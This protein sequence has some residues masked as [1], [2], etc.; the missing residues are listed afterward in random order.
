VVAAATPAYR[1]PPAVFDLAVR[2]RR[3]T[4]AEV[5]VAHPWPVP[6]A[7]FGAAPSAGVA[8]LMDE[9]GVAFRGGFAFT[10]VHADR[11]V[12]GGGAVVEFDVALLVPPHRPPAVVAASPLAGPDG[13]MRVEFPSLRHLEHRNVFGVGDVIA[14]TLRVGMAGTLGVFEGAFA[15]DRIAAELSGAVPPEAPRMQAICFLDTGTTGSLLHC[16][17]SAPAAGTGPAAC[18]LMPELPFFR[19]AKRLF[20]DDWFTSMVTGEVA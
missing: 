20:A 17:F 11:L 16:D 14:P 1:C 15:A 10:Q 18:T 4:G 9:A 8:R 7:P 12:E 3:H 13:W 6:L 2:L 5:T 19:T